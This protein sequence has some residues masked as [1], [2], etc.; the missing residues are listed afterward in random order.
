MPGWQLHEMAGD[1][2]GVSDGDLRRIFLTFKRRWLLA[3]ASHVL[4]GEA[5]LSASHDEVQT[6][7]WRRR[8]HRGSLP[9]SSEKVAIDE[10]LMPH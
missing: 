7:G 6:W 10:L 5:R 9:H 1:S 3:V 8:A 4:V 2:V